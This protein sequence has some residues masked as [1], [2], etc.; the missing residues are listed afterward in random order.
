MAVAANATPTKRFFVEMITRDISLEDAILDLIDNSIDSFIRTRGVELSAATLLETDLPVLTDKQGKPV[1][2][3]VTVELRSDGFRI[4]DK[5]GGIS[6]KKAQD[7][8]FRF[9]APG[10]RDHASLGVYGIGLK[11]AIFKLGRHIRITSRTVDEGFEIHLDAKTWQENPDDWTI[12][13]EFIDG[14]GSVEEAGTVIEISELYPNVKARITDGTA[15]RRLF[16]HIGETYPYFL[17][18]MVTV[19]LNGVTVPATEIPLGRSEDVTPSVLYDRQNG[20]KVTLVSGLAD[21]AKGDWNTDRAGWYVLCNGRVVVSADKTELTGWGAGGP[22]FVSKYRGFV[23]IAFFFANDPV[24]LPWTT[25]KRGINRESPAFIKARNQMQVAARPVLTFLNSL[26]PSDAVPEPT[27]RAIAEEVR[28]ADIKQVISNESTFTV[29][30]RTQPV[31][32]T[33]KIQ[34]DALNSDIDLIRKCLRKPRMSAKA[35]GEHTFK[36]FVE[37][38]CS[39]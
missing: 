29:R 3:A 27:R 13:M 20:V 31:R 30:F 14:V 10:D 5:T 15:E 22:Q 18:R 23:G 26:Y 7:E 4:E 2:A 28:Q 9:G 11:R 37:M 12:P 32:M 17:G 33:T 21:R 1:L 19:A 25:T 38:E 39:E 16:K 36:Y 6:R 24:E 35:I 34:Y 8:V